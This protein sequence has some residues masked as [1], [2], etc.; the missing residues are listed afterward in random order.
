MQGATSFTDMNDKTI[1]GDASR[2]HLFAFF[3]PI[4]CRDTDATSRRH[5]IGFSPPPCRDTDAA[6]RRHP[7]GFSPPPCRDTDATSRRHPIGFF[8]PLFLRRR[9]SEPPAPVYPLVSSCH[10]ANEKGSLGRPLVSCCR[11]PPH[12]DGCLTPAENAPLSG[13]VGHRSAASPP[14]SPPCPRHCP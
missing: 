2:P 5:P 11:F 1:G 12:G 13:P 14:R 10:G 3:P 6:N 7:I 4:P 8:P 9:C